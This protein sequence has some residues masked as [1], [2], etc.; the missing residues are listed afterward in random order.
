MLAGRKSHGMV[1][2]R[3]HLFA[4]MAANTQDATAVYQVPAGQT[5]RVGVQVGI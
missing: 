5:M 2:W 4:R 1:A 3:D